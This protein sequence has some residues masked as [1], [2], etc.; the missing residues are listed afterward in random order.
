MRIKA[1]PV[2]LKLFFIMFPLILFV[3]MGAAFGKSH[4]T[5][6][7]DPDDVH[8]LPL[9][10]VTQETN[11]STE[12]LGVFISGDGGWWSIDRTVS[13]V[14]AANGVP[15]VGLSSYK[16]F[17]K[18]RTPDSTAVEM[19][20]IIRHYLKA[21][22]KERIILLGYSLGGE[23]IPF[24]ATRLQEDLRNRVA[25]LVMIGPAKR[26]MFEFHPTDWIH[27]PSKQLR[28][29]VQPEIEKLYNGPKLIC[30]TSED[31]SECICNKLDADKVT[32]VTRKGGHDY[33]GDS[34]G[35]GEAI[36]EA[37]KGVK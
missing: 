3:T 21:W 17:A 30:T 18:A 13:E 31:D 33:E 12:M 25:A 20:R 7:S 10:E 8:D 35:L 27:T 11:T 22:K 6:L 14:M 29:F 19:E 16:Y 2:S 32:V 5:N 23:I 34:R 28:Y 1:I 37:L 15:V 9:T 36:W 24:V 26:T 4:S